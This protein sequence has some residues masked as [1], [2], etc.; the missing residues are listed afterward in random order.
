MVARYFKYVFFVI[1]VLLI[2]R[3]IR[4]TLLYVVVDQFLL[5]EYAESYSTWKAMDTNYKDKISTNI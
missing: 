2:L 5:D 1:V 4:A 3:T